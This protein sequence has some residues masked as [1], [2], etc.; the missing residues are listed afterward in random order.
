[1]RGQDATTV[2]VNE[3]L[4]DRHARGEGSCELVHDLVWLRVWAGAPTLAITGDRA[5]GALVPVRGLQP[6]LK[7]RQR[8]LGIRFTGKRGVA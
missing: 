8:L 1:M 2:L 6:V 3:R 4:P 7:G 5:A